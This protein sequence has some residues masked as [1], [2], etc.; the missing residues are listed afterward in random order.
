M[1]P[2]YAT[3]EPHWQKSDPL[4]PLMA[5]PSVSAASQPGT[6]PACGGFDGKPLDTRGGSSM[7]ATCVQQTWRKD[8]LP[9]STAF[10]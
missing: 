5:L 9:L 6:H 8:R 3:L 10:V 1:M 4:G 2:A 7:E